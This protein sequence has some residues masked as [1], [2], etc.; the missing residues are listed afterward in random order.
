VWDA[1]PSDALYAVHGSEEKRR[2][3]AGQVRRRLAQGL[4]RGDC[5]IF[6]LGPEYIA[7]RFKRSVESFGSRLFHREVPR[8]AWRRSTGRHRSGQFAQI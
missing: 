2:I 6:R 5:L 4:R 7:K 3:I 8:C 1:I